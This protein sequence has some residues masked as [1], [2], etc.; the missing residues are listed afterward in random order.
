MHEPMSIETVPQR[1][2]DLVP[3]RVAV[4]RARTPAELAV[5][6]AALDAELSR[7]R[8]I[9]QSVRRAVSE[10]LNGKANIDLLQVRAGPV[11]GPRCP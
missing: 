6:V 1:E 9:D 5:A 7:R 11:V 10:L 2:A 3:L 4:Q 8:R